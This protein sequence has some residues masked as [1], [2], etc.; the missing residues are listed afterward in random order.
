MGVASAIDCLTGVDPKTV[1]GLYFAST[2]APYRE[3]QSASI[4]AAALDL[5][6]DVATIDFGNSLGAG[7]G[8]LKVALDA[9]N[10]G[11][12]RKVLVIA[13]DCRMPA[14]N[15]AFEPVFGDGA[16][17]FVMEATTERCGLYSS[18]LGSDGS[19]GH[20]LLVPAGGSAEP[21]GPDTFAHGRQ[22]ARMNGREVFRFAARII[23]V[24]CRQAVARAGLRLGDIDWI[25]PHAVPRPGSFTS[26][27]MT[28]PFTRKSL[29]LV[30][31][32]LVSYAA[33][34]G[35]GSRRSESRPSVTLEPETFVTAPVTRAPS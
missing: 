26:I 35:E 25:V 20:H 6:R 24:A 27:T 17:A 21:F 23:G 18:A 33:R 10:A 1:D 2:T 14:P 29:S 9:V 4:I 31:S 30:P 28:P 12:A 34:V 5:R 13:S 3:K 16:A 32:P 8:A 7:A 19:Q 11:S 22:Y 15:S